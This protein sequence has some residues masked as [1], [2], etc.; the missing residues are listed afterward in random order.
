MTL[1]YKFILALACFP[2][3]MLILGAVHFGRPLAALLWILVTGLVFSTR[4][5][6]ATLFMAFACGLCILDWSWRRWSKP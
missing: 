1:A 4:H 5:T 2:P 6:E 3:A